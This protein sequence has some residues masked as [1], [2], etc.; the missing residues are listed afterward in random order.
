[1]SFKPQINS[2]SRLLAK[3]RNKSQAKKLFEEKE[4][5]SHTPRINKLSVLIDEHKNANVKDRFLRLY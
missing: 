3:N 1:M 5:F 2:F 4:V